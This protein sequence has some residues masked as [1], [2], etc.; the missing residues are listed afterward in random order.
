[1]TAFLVCMFNLVVFKSVVV[2]DN[3]FLKYER[4]FSQGQ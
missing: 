3:L 4:T 2:F 1:M